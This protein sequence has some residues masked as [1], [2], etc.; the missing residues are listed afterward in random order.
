MSERQDTLQQYTGDMIAL[1]K[2]IHEAIERQKHDESAKKDHD[3]Y[4]IITRIDTILERQIAELEA[5]LKML[6]GDAATPVKDA[7]GA[8]TGVAAG[9]IDKVRSNSVS[10]MLRDDYTALS[11]AA[12]GYTLLHTT[13]VALKNKPT[14][15]AAL[16][17]LTDITP[18]IV[19]ISETIS[20][21]AVRELRDETE[22]I[23]IAAGPEAVRNTQKAWNREVVGK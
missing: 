14:A 12:M 10:K 3:A 2:H 4:P 19:D 21:V 5:H 20:L 11:L 13:G 1:T 17:M 16:Q 8:L 18:L 9:V 22:T 23:D 15:D 6:G 7:V